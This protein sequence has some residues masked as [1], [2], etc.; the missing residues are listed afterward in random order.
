MQYSERP[1]PSSYLNNRHVFSR[2][3]V[4]YALTLPYGLG[5]AFCDVWF[6]S[7][8]QPDRLAHAQRLIDQCIE[9]GN[10]AGCEETAVL[11]ED[12][13][14]GE[15]VSWDQKVLVLLARGGVEN[16]FCAQDIL[17]EQEKVP[18]AAM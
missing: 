10:V 11:L 6:Y 12:D 3:C 18:S 8:V 7:P 13:L 2:D 16:L 15:A 1:H 4:D 17:S 14:K 5:T 9:S